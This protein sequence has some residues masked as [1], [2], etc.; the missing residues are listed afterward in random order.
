M[1]QGAISGNPSREESNIPFGT[2]PNGR[3][4]EPVRGRRQASVLARV[5]P[6]LA[7]AAVVGLS[8]STLTVTRHQFKQGSFHCGHL[9]P[10]WNYRRAQV[11]D[12][13]FS[14]TI[15]TDA[16]MD[17]KRARGSIPLLSRFLFHCPNPERKAIRKQPAQAE[18]QTVPI[19]LYL[20]L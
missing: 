11:S 9:R 17:R 13:A 6:D 4:R 7:Q 18:R 2:D 3:L 10:P 8:Q 15:F 16:R 12:L 5:G 14:P 1:G 19:R 20:A